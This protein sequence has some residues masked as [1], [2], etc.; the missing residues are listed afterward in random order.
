VFFGKNKVERRYKMNSRL[1]RKLET[2]VKRLL[3][4]GIEVKPSSFPNALFIRFAGEPVFKG[5]CTIL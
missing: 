4:A 3:A 1:Q 2:M 5:V